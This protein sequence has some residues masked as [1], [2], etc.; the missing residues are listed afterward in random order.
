MSFFLPS[1]LVDLDYLSGDIDEEFEKLAKPYQ[2]D[3]D[4]AFFAVNFGYSKH[5][6]LC[7][8]P[9]EKAF[10]IKAWENK[11]I[12]DSYDM[13]N[14]IFVATYNINRKKGKKALKLWKKRTV[15]KADMSNVIE[16]I[17]IIKEMDKREGTSWV[18]LIYQKNGMKPP[19]KKWPFKKRRDT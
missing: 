3:M 16:S 17:S 6:Y 15:K 19:R 1:R 9:R 18:D 12:S 5:D 11:R 14:A 13:Y 10:I 2:N 4:F 8:T 7:L